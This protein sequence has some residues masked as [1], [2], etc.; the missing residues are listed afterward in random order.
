MDSYTSLFGIE[1]IPC[2]QTLAHLECMLRW[3]EYD[4]IRD[5]DNILLADEE[6]TYDFIREMFRQMAGNLKSRRINIGMDEAHMLGLGAHLDRYGYENRMDIML[7]HYRRVAEIAESFGYQ[8]MMW[9]DMFFRL[10]THGE[11]YTEEE[12][13]IDPG[14]GAALSDDI[15]L[16]YWDYYTLEEKST[17]NVLQP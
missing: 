10:A 5:I 13:Q 2:I 14:V 3:K 7:R 12:L 17:Q 15:T 9:S 1:L 11:Y 16:I 6:K 4:G 8:P